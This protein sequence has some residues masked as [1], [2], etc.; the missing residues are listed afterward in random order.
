MKLT[1]QDSFFGWNKK[2]GLLFIIKDE[3]A[4]AAQTHFVFLILHK[5]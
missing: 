3:F 5:K 2:S 4:E 1:S